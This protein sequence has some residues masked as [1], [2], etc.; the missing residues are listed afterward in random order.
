MFDEK[1]SPIPKRFGQEGYESRIGKTPCEADHIGCP[2][3]HWRDQ[4]DLTDRQK[5]VIDLFRASLATGGRSLT[6]AEAKDWFLNG[7]FADLMELNEKAKGDR[8]TS[9]VEQLALAMMTR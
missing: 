9:A 5:S 6:D 3:G 2:K 4:P 7:V 8:M 1:G